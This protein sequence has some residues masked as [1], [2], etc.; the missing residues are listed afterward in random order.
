MFDSSIS[1]DS[2]S[3]VSG[4]NIDSSTI[5]LTWKAFMIPVFKS[6]FIFI[7]CPLRLYS[8]LYAAARAISIVSKTF[9]FEMLFSSHICSI[10]EANDFV[11]IILI[12]ARSENEQCFHIYL[13]LR[14][15]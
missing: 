1:S 8:F 14:L 2:S 9:S 12:K 11:S 3:S 7:F 15:S 4:F 5:N 13:D 6:N 10:A